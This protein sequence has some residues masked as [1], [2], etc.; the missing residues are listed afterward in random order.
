MAEA[1]TGAPGIGDMLADLIGRFSAAAR[2]RGMPAPGGAGSAVGRVAQAISAVPNSQVGADRVTCPVVVVATIVT[3]AGDI[4]LRGVMLQANGSYVGTSN[5]EGMVRGTISACEGQARLKAIYENPDRRVKN[6]EFTLEITGIDMT[7]RRAT[8]GAARNFIAK[9]Q[10]VFG[11]G[12]AGFPGDKDFVDSYSGADLVRVPVTGAAELH[13]TIKLATL[14]LNV[15]YR[16]QNDSR[17]VVQGVASSGGILCMP[18]S[19][20][21]QAKYWGIENV[22][23]DKTGVETRSAMTRLDIMNRAQ[24][25][26]PNMSL[27]SFPRPWQSWDNLNGTIRALAEAANPGSYS[28]HSGPAGGKS[29]VPSSYADSLT[30]LI[31]QGVPVVTSTTATEG[32]VMIVTGA[33]VKHDWLIL[34]DP[35]GT[36]ASADSIYGTLALRGAVGQGAPNAPA[37]VRAVQE[38][39]T[40]SGHYSGEPG[41]RID[42]ADPNDP[43]IAAIRRFQGRS[44]DGVISPGGATEN[45]L[46]ARV[47]QGASTSY[48]SAEN[49]RNGPTD[50]RGRH[51]YYNGETEGHENGR[52]RLKGQAFTSVISP[53]TALTKA[54]VAARL[55]PGTA[56]AQQEGGQQ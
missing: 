7:A 20:E 34:N 15:P 31:A 11:S 3:R 54:Q 10:D 50:D 56:R 8:G 32:H 53:T 38:A 47:K 49:E 23:T 35:N 40:R 36:L 27:A 16:N 48:S 30:G 24:K 4:P 25:R 14:S 37:D 26:A 45:R 44:A 55:N 6:E 46:N 33:V 51:V 2:A 12:A 18:S 1:Q 13:V 5:A 52:F 41:A 17:E 42:G 22:T 28:V 21:M 43:T 29:S 19:A 9:V 39:L